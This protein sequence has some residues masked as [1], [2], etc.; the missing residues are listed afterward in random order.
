M[1]INVKCFATL[2]EDG[3]CDYKDSKETQL[4]NDADVSD[5]ITHLGLQKDKVEIVFV[6][7]IKVGVDQKLSE[8]DQVGLFPAVGGM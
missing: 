1:K 4:K 3:H 7:G 6:N 2:S 8:G 5:L